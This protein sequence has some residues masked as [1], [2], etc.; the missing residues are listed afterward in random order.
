M[1]ISRGVQV[2]SIEELG[3]FPQRNWSSSRLG[4]M[5]FAIR[6]PEQSDRVILF[7]LEDVTVLL[8]P[9]FEP[10]SEATTAAPDGS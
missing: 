9:K 7:G 8:H 10:E 1:S 5:R 2:K 4:G 3:L 6:H